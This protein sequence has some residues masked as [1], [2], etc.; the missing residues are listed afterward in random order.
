[1]SKVDWFRSWHGA[2]TDP[3]WLGIARKAGVV[4]GTV[5][6]V[7]WALFD[8]ASQA[9]ERGSIEGYDA[10]GLAA[11]FGCEP[12]QVE[13]IIQAM[14]DKG[15]IEGN[16]LAAWEK[17]Q[18]KREDDSAERVR[19]HRERKKQQEQHPVTQRN[20]PEKIL[21]KDNTTYEANA[22]SVVVH[23]GT[24]EPPEK[25]SSETTEAFAGY[26]A[27]AKRCDWPVARTLTP[28]RKAALAARLREC[29]GLDG[30]REALGRA[31][32][33]DFLCGRVPRDGPHANWTFDLDCLLQQKTFTRLME[34]RYDNRTGPPANDKPEWLRALG[35]VAQRR[36]AMERRQ[37]EPAEGLD[38][39]GTPGNR[40][41]GGSDPGA[42]VAFGR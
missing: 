42:V 36:D 31:E 28:P 18:P 26:N 30:W 24:A 12:E 33:S 11:F 34:G 40:S 9:E 17:R 14:R 37:A 21:D 4:P 2:P 8:R 41:D 15:M 1:M 7:A 13:A 6:A 35:E 32:R 20:A 23:D 19:Q 27:A 10:D 16:R 25:P 39:I 5:V 3:K 22:S 38:A 29:G